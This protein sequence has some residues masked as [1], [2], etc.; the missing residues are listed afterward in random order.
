MT[1]APGSVLRTHDVLYDAEV[2][3]RMVGREMELL[4]LEI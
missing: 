3:L 1:Q 2:V 4:L